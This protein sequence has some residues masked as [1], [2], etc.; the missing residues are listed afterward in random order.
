[1]A[2][3]ELEVEPRTEHGKGAN[4][5]LRRAGYVPAVVYGGKGEPVPVKIE[6]RYLRKQ[7]ENEAFASHILALRIEGSR[8]EQAVLKALQRH[9]VSERVLHVDLQ[10]VVATEKITITVPIHVLGEESCPGIKM[11]GVLFR[12]LTEVEVLCLPG[13]LPESIDIDISAAELG[14]VV[15]LSEVAAPEG[16][17][18][19]IL[20][21]GSEHDPVVLT[22]EQPRAEEVEEGEA[23]EE[24]VVPAAP[25]AAGAEGGTEE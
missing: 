10:R 25:P 13:D 5:R 11:G 16:V 14:T 24:G 4:R 6:E 18:F 1:M 21:L 9:P 22:I 17:E 20:G 7:L 15:H 3:F 8:R 23:L 19:T 2:E 12:Q